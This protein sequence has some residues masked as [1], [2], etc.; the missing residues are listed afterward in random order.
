MLI[1]KARW[2]FTVK[3]G[4]GK[5]MKTFLER[6][7]D[8]R[9]MV[10]DGG[11]G[12]EL[13]KGRI[14]LT[15]SALANELHPA[16]VVDIHSDYIEMGADV[17]GTNTFV[18]SPLHL[19]MAGKEGTQAVTIARLAMEHARTAVEKSGREIYIAGSIGPSPGAIEADAGD[20]DFGIADSKA[21]A[22]HEQVI[23]ALAEGGVDLICIETMFSAKEAAIAADVARKTGLPIAINLTCK[24]TKDRKTGEVIYRTDWGHSSESLLEFL[25]S[26]EFSDG[27]NLLE[28]VQIIGMNCG[29]ENRRVEH[30]G[31]SYA[32]N[33]IRQLRQALEARG[34]TGIRLMAYPNAGLPQLEIKTGRTTYSHTAEDMARVRPRSDRRGRLCCGRLLRDGAVAYPGLPRDVERGVREERERLRNDRRRRAAKRGAL[35]TREGVTGGR[36][37]GALLEG[38][39]SAGARLPREAAGCAA[40]AAA[41]SGGDRPAGHEG[42]AGRIGG[43][44]GALAMERTSPASRKPAGGSAGARRGP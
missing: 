20:T 40:D 44:P 4:I 35:K 2:T 7:E 25:S 13:F 23:H 16:A 32:I 19:E 9:P 34:I 24:Y 1:E 28:Y 26:G 11:F 8:S 43:V 27:D 41:V 10:Y 21:R 5:E 30:T 6:L 18:A 31:M 29:A 42:G 15:N 36:V 39:P 3:G 37:P 38:Y 17:I 14:E 22:A 12:S 33:G